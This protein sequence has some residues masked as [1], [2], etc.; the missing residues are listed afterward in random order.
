MPAID[1]L[2]MRVKEA[3]G[4]DLHL[5]DGQPPWMRRLGQVAAL[6]NEP[7]L[8]PDAL[9]ALLR[10]IAPP[11][12]WERGERA[13]DITFAYSPDGRTRFRVNCYRHAGGRGAACR[14]IPDASPLLMELGLAPVLADLA[15]LHAGLVLVAGQA[16]AGLSTTI[17]AL[18]NEV[19]SDQT[20]RLLTLE[21]TIEFIIPSRHSTV[22]Q[23]QVGPHVPS[24]IAGLREAVR[25]GFDVVYA[26]ELRSREL[27][28]LA[29][30]VAES[31]VLVLATLRGSG[32]VRVLEHILG[33]F[34]E[35]QHQW[36]RSMLANALRGLSVQH[37]V[38]MA[39][40]AWR[41]AVNEVLVGTPSVST[42]I[43]EG[44]ISKLSVMIQAGA[45]DGMI[46]M[47]ESLYKK[48]EA[49]AI[50]AAEALAHAVEKSR[51]QS[52]VKETELPP[53][54]SGPASSAKVAVPGP[55]GLAGRTQFLPRR[56]GA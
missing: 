52:L 54:A 10:E 39:D 28:A 31:G 46:T 55:Q 34:P 21:D 15:K 16:G 36:A 2:L 51:F 33:Q 14:L 26:G 42:A 20:R 4:S 12:S 53:P 49:K 29:L 22:V 50:T 13:G 48:L 40:G 18:C 37:L 3:G 45:A 41:C 56:P 27:T 23:R 44:Y 1:R 32:V 8:G 47:D 5:A 7:A 6:Q 24:V 25:G 38:N 19:A 17:A 30:T 43:R 35:D 11:A 9:G